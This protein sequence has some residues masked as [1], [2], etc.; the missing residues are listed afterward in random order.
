MV[1]Y[2]NYYMWEFLKLEKLWKK[3]IAFISNVHSVTLDTD[4]YI[5]YDKVA[6]FYSVC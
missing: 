1:T 3:G 5:A 6:I 2:R 4:L